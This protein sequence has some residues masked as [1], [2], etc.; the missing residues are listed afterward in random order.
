MGRELYAERN[1]GTLMTDLCF[2]FKGWAYN[3]EYLRRVVDNPYTMNDQGDVRYAYTGQG[4]NHQVSYVFPKMYEVA[5]RY[6]WLDPFDA[7]EMNEDTREILE[8]GATKYLR[9]HRVKVQLSMFYDIS[10]HNYSLQNDNN[11]WGGLFQIELGI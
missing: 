11:S 4:T 1:I 8:I 5:F 9:K 7:I 10:N 3:A 6:S 2:K